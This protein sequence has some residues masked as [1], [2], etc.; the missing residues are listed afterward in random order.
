MVNT[1]WKVYYCYSAEGSSYGVNE[2]FETKEEA[3]A[4][5]KKHFSNMHYAWVSE[6]EEA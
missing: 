1:Y 3:L 4:Y 2:C 6:C 5:A